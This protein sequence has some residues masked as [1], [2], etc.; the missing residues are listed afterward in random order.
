MSEYTQVMEDMNQ[1]K[2]QTQYDEVCGQLN[3]DE[4]AKENAWKS[5]KAIYNDYILEGSQLD[6]LACSLYV[7]CRDSSTHTVEG[8]TYTGNSINLTQILR[9]TNMKYVPTQ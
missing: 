4:E 1:D 2:V 5:Y 3:L 8:D 7:A 9:A 6:W